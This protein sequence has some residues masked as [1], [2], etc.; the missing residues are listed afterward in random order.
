MK[1]FL[2]ILSLASLMIACGGSLLQAQ[3]TVLSLDDCRQLAMQN[4]IELQAAQL[5]VEGAHQVRRQAFTKYF[6]TISASAMGFDATDGIVNFSLLDGLVT[7]SYIEKGYTAGVSAVQP[8]FAGGQIV[9]NNRLARVGEEVKQVQLQQR[10][11]DIALQVEQYYWQMVSLNEK[12]KTLDIIGCQIDTICRDVQAAADAG[13]VMH[14][15]LLQAELQRNSIAKDRLK[16]ENGLRVTKMLLA[17]C[18]SLPADSFDIASTSLDEIPSPESLRID[19]NEA[20]YTTYPYQLLSKSIEASRLQKKI[21]LG[22]YL[23]QVGVGVGYMYSHL[24]DNNKIKLLD[25]NTSNG[26]VFATVKIPISDWWGGSHAIREKNTQIKIAEYEMQ[27]SSQLLLIQMQQLWNELVEA[28]KQVAISQESV[29]KA[30]ENLRLNSDS[31]Q[32]GVVPMSELL[33]AQSLLQQ[34]RDQ[35]VTDITTYLVKRTQY[36]QATGR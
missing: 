18:I 25:D 11:N 27:N 8:L 12:L 31:Y 28:Y 13:I 33:D 23:P 29:A 22:K 19:H 21:E 20:L 24:P 34:T 1:R 36:Q 32:A 10:Q 35:L 2:A 3:P 26:V 17:H 14:N 30:T 15:D 16:V 4:N 7:A 9:N 6:P 5:Q